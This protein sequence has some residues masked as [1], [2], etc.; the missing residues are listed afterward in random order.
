MY[1]GP[2]TCPSA[3]VDALLHL[4]SRRIV[5]LNY[6]RALESR[7]AELDVACESRVIATDGAPAI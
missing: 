3:T 2:P 7:A 5:T 6:D 1:D 4:R